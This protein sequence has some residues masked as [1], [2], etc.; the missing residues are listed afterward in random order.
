MKILLNK[1]HMHSATFI[2]EFGVVTKRDA[3]KIDKAKKYGFFFSGKKEITI[4]GG[5]KELLLQEIDKIAGTLYKPYKVYIYTDAQVGNRKE[6]SP[7]ESI[8]TTKQKNDAF[9]I[10]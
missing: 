6:G 5:S 8:L 7:I 2:P 3:V 4:H 9:Y 10:N 1:Y